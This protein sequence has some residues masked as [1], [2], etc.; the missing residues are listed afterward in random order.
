MSITPTAGS[1]APKRSGR[2]VMQAPTSRPPLDPPADR[3]LGRR[4]VLV[5]DQP[6]GRGDEVVEDVLLLELGAGLVPVLA[7]FAAAAQVGL[8]RNSPP[9]SIQARTAGLKLGVSEM[10]N[11]P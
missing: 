5:R 1:A 7:V 9:I 3:Q 11:P 4:R 6:L 2:W 10:L 8:R